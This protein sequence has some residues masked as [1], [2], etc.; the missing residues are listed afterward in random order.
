VDGS[1]RGPAR[2]GSGGW[3]AVAS[4]GEP[5]AAH[6]ARARLEALGIDCVLADEHVV[7]VSWLWSSALGGVKVLVRAGDAEAA[8]RELEPTARPAS[9]SSDWISAD[10][11]APRCPECGCLRIEASPV[12]RPIAVASWLLLGVPLLLRQRRARCLRCGA[13]FAPS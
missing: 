8:E 9:P 6:L 10:L 1:A 4:Y 11:D 7:G 13:R 5:I 12:R 3:V 2:W